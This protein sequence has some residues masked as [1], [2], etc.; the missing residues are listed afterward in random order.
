ML[1]PASFAGQRHSYRV[2]SRA[3]PSS[4][5]G[6]VWR[7]AANAVYALTLCPH[8]VEVITLLSLVITV[9]QLS[10]RHHGDASDKYSVTTY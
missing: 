3:T 9:V 7:L 4:G 6:R 8:C 5:G 1:T 2:G 10:R